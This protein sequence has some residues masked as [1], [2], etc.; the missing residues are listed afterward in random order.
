M[1]LWG[2][3]RNDP[4]N[5]NKGVL[6]GWHIDG[7]DP[8]ADVRLLEYCLAVPM[9]QFLHNGTPRAL[10]RHALAD[11]LPKL[12]VEERRRGLQAADWH[13]RL[14]AVRHCV[15]A[16]LD[17]LDACAAATKA[18]DL[19]RLHRLVEN[20]P[21][22]G[23]ERAEVYGPYRLALARAISAG[24]FLRRVGGGNHLTA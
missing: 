2:F 5:Y 3:H 24:H 15:A 20:W 12:V 23:W 1:R 16:E 11:R 7:R 22:G 14:T 13:E 9:E 8:T 19:P 18:L 4:G 17:R 21:A 6:A 10:A